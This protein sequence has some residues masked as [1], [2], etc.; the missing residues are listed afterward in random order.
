MYGDAVIAEQQG[1][2]EAALHLYQRSFRMESHVDRIY[3]Q[4]AMLE[5]SKARSN[6]IPATKQDAVHH[7]R[8]PSVV[9]PAGAH[10][11]SVALVPDSLAE[12]LVSFTSQPLHFLPEDERQG[13]PIDQ[14]PDELIVLI[15]T[16]FADR[17][18]VQSVERFGTVCRKA[19]LVSLD[20]VIWR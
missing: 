15:L 19:R 6:T 18:D 17:G 2:Y 16:N 10:S 12:I 7:H 5:E 4:V 11:E 13:V 20:P 1:D 14:L 8:R 3:N 9:A